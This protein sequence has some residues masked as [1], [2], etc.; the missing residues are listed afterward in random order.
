MKRVLFV[1]DEQRVLDGL[2]RML[3][4]LR[5]EWRMDFVASPREALAILSAAEYDVLVTDLRMPEMSGLELLAEVVKR[6]P[7]VVRLVLSGTADHE[8]TIR[9]TALAHQYLVKPCDAATLRTTVARAFSLRVMLG[10]PRLKQLIASIHTLPS[11]PTVYARLVEMLQNPDVSPNEIGQVVALDMSMTAKVLQLANSAFFGVRRQITNP[12]EA[13]IYLGGDTVRE[14]LLVASVFSAF[15][16]KGMRHF[17]IE[18]LQD[19]SLAVGAVVRR[20]AESARLTKTAADQAYVGGLLHAVGKLVLASKYPEQYDEA[21]HHAAKSGT[22]ERME[23]LE[24]FGTTH[25]E[26]GAYLLWLWALPD[27][28][29]EVVL[30]HHEFPVDLATARTPA[31]VVYLADSLAKEG[32]EQQQAV[33][34]LTSMGLGDKVD[35]WKQAYQLPTGK[36]SLC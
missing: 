28:V 7:G 35:G 22:A 20:I 2:Q 31:G 34:C 24:A 8:V 3:Y 27:P 32:L 4:P 10:D 13:V 18:S 25:A 9:S 33:E 15:R 26:I 19:H 16:L 30:R 5:S 36:P 6:H 23:E 1:D 29:S 12:A 17:S 14:L 21:I 11:V